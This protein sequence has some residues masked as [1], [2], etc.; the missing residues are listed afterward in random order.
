VVSLP[1]VVGRLRAAGCV[2]AEDE[3]ELL[4]GAARD[5]VHLESMITRRV[6][7]APL[8]HVLGWADFAGVRV[9]VTDGV[10]VPRHR[11][12]L[13]TTTA[14]GLLRE[15]GTVLDL[16]CGTGALGLVVCRGVPGVRLVAADVDPAAVECARRNLAP[17]GAEVFRGDLF[18]PLPGELRGK[19]DLLLA[20]VPYVPTGE[21]AFLPE[22]FRVHEA[23]AALDGGADGLD[24]LRRVAASVGEW[25][26]PGGSLLTEAGATQLAEAHAVLAAAGLRPRTVFDPESETSVVVASRSMV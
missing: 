12:E 4:A 19:V 9:T 5:A 1:D 24:V 10:F 22:E 21:I 26:A 15:G 25:L 14:R 17:L 8:E 20:N 3:A 13:L 16:C 23:R 11:T 18:A 6:A 7:G 2:F